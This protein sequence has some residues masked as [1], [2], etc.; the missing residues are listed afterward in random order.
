MF[1]RCIVAVLS[2]PMLTSKTVAAAKKA[3]KATP[4]NIYKIDKGIVESLQTTNFL[5]SDSD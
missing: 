3:K 1:H 4:L 2:V 5:D